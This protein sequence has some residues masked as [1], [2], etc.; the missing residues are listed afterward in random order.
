MNINIQIDVSKLVHVDPA[1][2]LQAQR[3]VL[4]RLVGLIEDE[5]ND[6]FLKVDRAERVGRKVSASQLMYF[7][8]LQEISRQ[9]QEMQHGLA[10]N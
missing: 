1:D 3:S 5:A 9:L 8:V 6:A 4:D 2:L 7:T 10:K